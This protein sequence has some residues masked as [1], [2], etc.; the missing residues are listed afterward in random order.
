MLADQLDY[1]VGVDPHR[2]SHALA[3][4]DVVSGAV[5]FEAN[6]A[7]R[8]ATATRRRSGS[9]RSTRRVGVRSRSKAPVPSAPD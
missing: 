2:D 6:I 8:A 9:L 4:V 3:V 1:V 5:V 7:R